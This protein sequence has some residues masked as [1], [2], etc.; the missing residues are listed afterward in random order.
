MKYYIVAGEA[1][2]DLHGSNLMKELKIQDSEAEFRFFGGDLM[3]TVGGELV[4]HY[5]DTAFMGFIPVI[6]NLRTILKNIKKCQEDVLFFNPDVLILIDYPGFNLKIAKFAFEN[7]LKVHY[8]ISPKIWAWKERRIKD[9]KAYVDKMITILPFET[10]FYRSHEM[11]VNYVGNPLF[12][13]ILEFKKTASKI[14]TQKPILA[15][16]PGSRKMELERMLPTMAKAAKLMETEYDVYIAATPDFDIQFYESLIGDLKAAFVVGET[17]K[18][19]NSASRGIITSGTATLEAAIF[20][21]P[22]VICY[23][24][25]ALIVAAARRFVK[26]K[27]LGLANLILDKEIVKELIQEDMTP[28]GIVEELSKF[29]SKE[30]AVKIE[31]DYNELLNVL[32]GE[33]ASKR[34]AEI[35]INEIKPK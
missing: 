20:K 21:V 31:K 35:I 29:D 30:G 2:G 25:P 9:I 17:Y 6:L 10:E 34:A 19:L 16:L 8:Y 12:D 26:V 5:R 15:V 27:Y 1:S 13:Q 7:G 3:K 24:G 28:E 14:E 23:H 4:N 32:G 18:L 11:E 22:Q 33:G